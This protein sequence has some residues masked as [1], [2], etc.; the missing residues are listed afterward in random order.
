MEGDHPHNPD[1]ADFVAT[2]EKP[3]PSNVDSIKA[4]SIEA[5]DGPEQRYAP[6]DVLK[7]E[8]NYS[9]EYQR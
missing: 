1:N 5:N 2:E 8:V 4:P 6:L 9:D 7:L 3:T